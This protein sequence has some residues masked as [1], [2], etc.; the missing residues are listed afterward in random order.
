MS[1][2]HEQLEAELDAG[3]HA[4]IG[5]VVSQTTLALLVVASQL[6]LEGSLNPGAR[7]LY[8]VFVRDA[9]RIG[10]FAPETTRLIKLGKRTP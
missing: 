3:L 4:Q 9:M 5:V 10:G 8:R 1:I 2:N 7:E 6:A